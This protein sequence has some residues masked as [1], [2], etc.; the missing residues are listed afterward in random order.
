MFLNALEKQNPALMEAAL[1]FWQRGEI[2]PDS[3]VIDVDQV[4]ENARLL[5]ATAAH[6]GLKLYLMSK[7]F[8]RNP[9]LCKLILQQ[10]FH[11]IVAVDFKEAQQLWQHGL[12]VAHVGHLVQL[13]EQLIDYAVAQRPE[14]ITVYSLEKAESIAA[15]ARRHNHIQPLLLKVVDQGDVVYPNQEAGFTLA[16]LPAVLTHLQAIE[17]ITIIGVTHFP[18][19][20]FCDAAQQTRPTPNLQTLLTA[21]TLLK[22]HGIA[23]QHVNAPSASSVSTLPLLAAHGVT[24]AEPGHALT[25]TLPA[26]QHG[27]G[28]EK[29]AMLYLSEISHNHQES[30]YCYGGGH[31][32]RSHM[33]RAAV[34]HQGWQH[35]AV[36]AIDSDSIDYTLPL[37]GHWP[38]G[39][40]VVMCF[41][42]QIFVTRSDVALIGG[43]SHGNPRLLGLFDSLGN[44]LQEATNE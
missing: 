36:K 2:R 3:Y 40:A 21:K 35:C 1:R 19:M 5:H 28:A 16:E 29:I 17:G 14:V 37:A 43:I 44:A 33:Q 8:G 4:L 22:Q 6:Y 18:C 30:S 20:A 25:G 12:P 38:I 27:D 13:P 11:G 39:S 31:Y 7:Q 34:W 24:H 23:V 41:R 26:N 42:T 9:L 10:G 32:R 15:A